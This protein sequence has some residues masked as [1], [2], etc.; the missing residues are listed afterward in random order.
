[1]RSILII[2]GGAAG[3]MA[4]HELSKHHLS[5]T[6]LEAKN[7]LGGRICTFQDDAFSRFIEAGAEF[8]HGNLPV[9]LDLLKEAGI[10]YHAVNDSMFY[11]KDGK[12]K[13]QDDF[14]DN[15]HK[16]MKAMHALKQDMPLDDFLNIFFKDDD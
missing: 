4:A 7:S 15:W 14:T 5:V 6:V 11:L 12:L 13:K 2:G 16:L 10:A 3:L 1:M 9:T 8:I